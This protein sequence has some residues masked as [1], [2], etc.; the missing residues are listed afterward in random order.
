MDVP[1][2]FQD[3]MDMDMAIGFDGF[4]EIF[5]ASFFFEVGI[6]E[7]GIFLNPVAV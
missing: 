6:D 4:G 2:F 7:E 1:Y 5:D 3:G